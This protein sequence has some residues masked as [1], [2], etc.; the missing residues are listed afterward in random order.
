MKLA[1]LLPTLE[2]GRDGIADYTARLAEQCED[3]GHETQLIPL[4]RNN[5]IT[6][7]R[8]LKE[9][10]A[11]AR[12]KLNDFSPDCLS[13][14]FDGRIFHP[15][16]IFPKVVVP[17][18]SAIPRKVHLMVHETWEGDE[19]HARLRRR[20]KGM[21][22]KRSFQ[23]ALPVIA[24]QVT[25][26]TN[27]I[28][29]EHLRS[30]GLTAE[31]LPLFSNCPIAL[32]AASRT[33]Y[34]GDVWEFVLFGGFRDYWD[35]AGFILRLK[36]CGRRVVVHH[37]GRHSSPKIIQ[38]LREACQGWAEFIEHGLQS[39]QEVS[40]ILLNCHFAISTY[41]LMLL[42]KS[43][44]YAAFLDHGLPVIVPRPD[45]TNAASD[46]PLD[47]PEGV[48]LAYDS[49]ESLNGCQRLP[50]RDGAKATATRF[51]QELSR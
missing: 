28:Y 22:Q 27:T 45:G 16:A 14:Q 42:R 3:Q 40:K 31:L 10:L 46:H 1:F 9:R 19:P 17:D 20:L 41:D 12:V 34:D 24:P 39:F 38:S 6:H 29:L 32:G 43:G 50:I 37:V 5:W 8:R 21:A 51:L 15:L 36:E 23:Q 26:T 49:L 44:V 47:I 13:W 35:P 33:D 7:P 30:C 11:E 2:F 18:F 4:G 48:I 25:H